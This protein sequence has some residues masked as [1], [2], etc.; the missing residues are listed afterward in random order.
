MEE[1]E[2]IEKEVNVLSMQFEEALMRV[3]TASGSG[4]INIKALLREC[5]DTLNRIDG[6]IAA[7]NR[8]Y[9]T[10]VGYRYEVKSILQK[11]FVDDAVITEKISAPVAK[12]LIADELISYLFN[13]KVTAPLIDQ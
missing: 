9:V 6:K 13:E 5:Q 1:Q 12:N 10:S 4:K 7:I 8:G 2:S 11:K 3:T